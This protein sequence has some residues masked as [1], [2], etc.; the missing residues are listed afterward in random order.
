MRS[1]YFDK[2]SLNYKGQQAN[3]TCRAVLSRIYFSTAMQ[4]LYGF[5]ILLCILSILLNFL[6]F[7]N[8][9]GNFYS[10]SRILET[11]EMTICILIVAEIS[12][13]MYLQGP[14]NWCS[15][16][17]IA[18][19][20]VTILCIIGLILSLQQD[21]LQSLGNSTCDTIMIIRNIVFLLRLIIIFKH[22]DDSKV[23][24]L[25]INLN[26]NEEELTTRNLSYPGI[27]PKYQPTMDTL[28]EEEEEEQKFSDAVWKGRRISD[29]Q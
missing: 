23:P 13:R 22:Q 25:E 6:I 19:L 10:E 28:F 4:V 14:S 7:D 5:L 24:S 21:V 27:N 2:R 9:S 16:G 29:K 8:L 12:L 15:L 26:T 1:S 3:N 18:D 11:L 17:N 20:T